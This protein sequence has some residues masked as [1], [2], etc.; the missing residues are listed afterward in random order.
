M[1]DE[2]LPPHDD[3]DEG[4]PVEPLWRA[5]LRWRLVGATMWPAF[6]V[7]TAFEAVALHLR[8]IAGEETGLVPA[9]LLSGF[10]NLA[11]VAIVA[12]VGG[13]LLRR[14][15]PHLPR[16]IAVDRAGTA[17][18][19]ALAVTLVAA[20][21]AH[22]GAVVE[23]EQDFA[24]QSGAVRQYVDN[25]APHQFQVNIDRADTWKQGPDLYR[26]CVPGPDPRKHLC[27][28]VE[29]DQR[30][31]GITRDTNQESNSRIAG[32]DNPGRIGG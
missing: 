24:A 30:P 32:A 16:D 11:I 13:R 9:F 29:T 19:L 17:F 3:L 18:L 14:R 23:E 5:R 22:H 26:T 21:L 27:L 6:G 25:Q 4:D 28:I 31:P 8:P 1:A 12:P 7:L 20:G 2:R 10:L 15:R